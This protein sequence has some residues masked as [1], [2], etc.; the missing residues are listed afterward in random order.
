MRLLSLRAKV[1]HTGVA[2]RQNS[3]G[4]FGFSDGAAPVMSIST[5]PI[6]K[7]RQIETVSLAALPRDFNV[8]RLKFFDEILSFYSLIIPD[9]YRLLCGRG[10]GTS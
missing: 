10:A 9:H 7:C 1:G 2:L 3:R 6:S 5:K 4:L 8:R